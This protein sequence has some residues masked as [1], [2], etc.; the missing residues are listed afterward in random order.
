MIMTAPIR[1]LTILLFRGLEKFE[2]HPKPGMN[3]VPLDASATFA[4]SFQTS[5]SAAI[6]RS[7]NCSAAVVHQA[8]ALVMSRHAGGRP[9]A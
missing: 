5:V 8:T 2:W 9:G 3:V 6:V 1:K 4:A 7:G